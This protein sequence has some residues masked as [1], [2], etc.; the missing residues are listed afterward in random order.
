MF[1]KSSILL[2]GSNIFMCWYAYRLQVLCW[3]SLQRWYRRTAQ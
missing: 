1:L 2:S 3:W